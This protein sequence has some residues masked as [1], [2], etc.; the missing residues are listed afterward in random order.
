MDEARWGEGEDIPGTVY[1]I[2][3]DTEVGETFVLSGHC[4]SCGLAGVWGVTDDKSREVARG[5]TVKGLVCHVRSL[6][7]I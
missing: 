7:F 2:C 5:Q 3:G 6:G 1:N 4:Q